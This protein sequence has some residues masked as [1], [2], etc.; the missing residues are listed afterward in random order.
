MTESRNHHFVPQGYLRGFGWKRGKHH[1]VI[2]HDFKE[3]KTYEANTRNVCAQRDFMRF[4]FNDR[5][6]DW[7]ENEL[8][9]LESNA[10]TAIRDVAS[11]GDFRGGNRNHILNLIAVLAVRSPEQR[12]S[13]RDFHA[14]VAERML[15]L[16][17]ENKEDWE[18][19]KR[20]MEQET[21]KKSP[22]TYEEA[23]D[24]HMRRQYR[25]EVARE[26][27]IQTEVNLHQTVLQL[28]DQR[29]WTLYLVSGD[30]GEFIT[31]SRPVVLTYINP[32]NVPAPL[33]YSPGFALENTEIYFPLTSK[34]LLVDRW[35]GEE[36]TVGAAPQTF[37]GVMNH[38]MIRHSYGLAMSASRKVLY[39]D[40]LMRLRW[41]DQ[42]ISR[43]TTQPSAE[44]V[45]QFKQTHGVL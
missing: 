11:S 29:R 4:D 18:K 25:I 35:D 38:Q 14:R 40:P 3:Q 30:Y 42:L 34:A 27:H 2:V 23:R 32:E 9:K 6:P 22:V 15:D 10:V 19:H 33:R 28:L 45:A 44:D 5:A 31:T 7:L 39:H 37:V 36:A 1:M 12:E 16:L 8:G 17:L 24:F 13:M 20:D 21:G 43:F 26:R 41:D